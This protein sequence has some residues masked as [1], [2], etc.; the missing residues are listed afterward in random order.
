[1]TRTRIAVG[2]LYV[3]ASFSTFLFPDIHTSTLFLASLFYA[4]VI[5]ICEAITVALNGTSLLREV[6][7]N[8][9]NFA[10]F[11]IVSTL[12]GLLLDGA[13]KFLA[14]LW[15]YP[16]WS[17]S[18][19]LFIFIPGFAAYWLAI[20]ESYLATKAVL[21]YLEKGV[22]TLHRPY[23]YEPFL[24]RGLG[25]LGAGLISVGAGLIVNDF[26]RQPLPLVLPDS[27]SIFGAAFAIS[28]W[29]LMLLALGVWFLLEF[30]EFYR[31]RTSL[32]RDIIHGY[33]TPLAAI[34]LGA[35]VLALLMEAQNI[36][37]GLWRYTNWPLDGYQFLGI[38]AIIFLVAWPLHYILFLSLFRVL[39]GK[40]SDQVWKGDVIR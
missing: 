17:S 30:L 26:A 10:S 27:V 36:P 20:T 33:W 5:Y 4:G 7:R 29:H 23:H 37:A 32:L 3:L 24:Y 38:P 40:E 9:K 14:K 1:M 21:D 11:V 2:I 16:S 39:T 28:F 12:G 34:V 18:F 8:G 15:V 25:V 19:Y 31:K 35:A 13:G 6:R 22:R